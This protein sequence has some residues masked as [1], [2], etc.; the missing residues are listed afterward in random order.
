MPL[1]ESFESEKCS[2]LSP[3]KADAFHCSYLAVIVHESGNS[4]A[5][6]VYEHAGASCL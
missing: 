4:F 3:A 2:E 6:I 1:R 5:H